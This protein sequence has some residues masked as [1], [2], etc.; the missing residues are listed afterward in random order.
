VGADA[1][2][3]TSAR[4]SMSYDDF[5]ASMRQVLQLDW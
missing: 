4:G 5:E 1:D 2:L 3:V